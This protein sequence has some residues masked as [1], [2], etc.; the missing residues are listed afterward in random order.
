M[1]DPT[2]NPDATAARAAQLSLEQLDR[3]Q[4]YMKLHGPN[5]GVAFYQ[6]PFEC[7]QANYIARLMSAYAVLKGYVKLTDLPTD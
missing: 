1:F 6:Q 2:A 5:S 4:S 7:G 3:L